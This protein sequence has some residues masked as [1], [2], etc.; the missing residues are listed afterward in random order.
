[1]SEDITR[2]NLDYL[3][4]SYTEEYLEAKA[5]MKESKNDGDKLSPMAILKDIVS[6]CTGDGGF[7]SF[8]FFLLCQVCDVDY[9]ML[10][11]IYVAKAEL[12]IFRQDHGYKEGTYIKTW[13]KR[14]DTGIVLSSGEDN[15]Y[16]MEWLMLKLQS[17]EKEVTDIQ[18][19]AFLENSYRNVLQ[20]FGIQD[21]T[22]PQKC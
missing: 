5:M 4:T 9:R 21:V 14:S 3:S 6:S 2:Y 10:Y 15:H 11:S 19:R 8:A 18:I 1:M 7:S 16:L 22:E 13:Q 17:K 20:M 12:N